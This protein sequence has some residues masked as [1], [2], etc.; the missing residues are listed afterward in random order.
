MP[1]DFCSF[2]RDE[3]NIVIET[4]GVLNLL[5]SIN[6][7]KCCGPDGIPGILL[8]TFAKCIVTSLASIFQYSLLTGTLPDI[9]KQAKVKPIFKKGSR[10]LPGNYR[11]VSLTCI[12]CKLLEHVINKHIHSH[13]DK[14]NILADSQHGFRSL[15]SCETQLVYVF[16]DLAYNREKGTITDV[17]ILDFTKAF[18]TVNH[19][20][21]LFKINKL[22]INLQ[23]INWIDS[24]LHDRRQIVVVDGKESA[25]CLIL[26]GVPQGS[27][28]GPLLFLMYVNDLPSSVKSEC[29]LFADDALIY[30]CRNEKATLQEDLDKLASWSQIWQLSFNPSKC[31]VL[32]IGG[33]EQV[34]HLNNSL[35]KNVPSHPYLGEKFSSNLKWDKHIDKIE[36]KANQRL[37]MLKRVLKTA[38][39]KTRKIAYET[40]V[41]PV[42]EY[43]SQVWDPYKKKNIKR[44]EKVQNKALRFI[45]AIK[46]SSQLFKVTK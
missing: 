38:D 5:K 27:V 46:K 17:I 10:N 21:L 4:E 16:N 18:D 42:L 19:R 37:G 25:P 34:Y 14:H 44:L 40:L 45:F 32:T 30:N 2:P 8:K 31:S 20:K 41:R 11:P 35:L 22:G 3:A 9:W 39:R 15:R 29:R 36:S 12:T 7:S 24:F 13:L 1:Q 28:L 43:G 33:S 23:V 26:S 6:T